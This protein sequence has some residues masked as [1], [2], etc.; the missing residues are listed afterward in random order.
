MFYAIGFSF[1]LD[2]CLCVV[3]VELSTVVVKASFHL[4]LIE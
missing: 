3:I 4:N 2:L 1:S